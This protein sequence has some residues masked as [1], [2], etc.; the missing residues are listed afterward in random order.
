MLYRYL[1]VIRSYL[2]LEMFY[3]TYINSEQRKCTEQKKTLA[4]HKRITVTYYWHERDTILNA[5]LT[6]DGT[7]S[8][9]FPKHFVVNNNESRMRHIEPTQM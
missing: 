5:H 6:V 9:T 3:L 7:I 1:R 2:T 8:N 4:Q